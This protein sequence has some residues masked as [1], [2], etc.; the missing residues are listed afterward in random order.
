MAITRI[1]LR[2]GTASQWSNANPVLAVREVGVETD[3]RS[4]KIGDGATPWSLLPYALSTVVIAALGADLDSLETSVS[5]L[6]ATVSTKA[7]A[8]V[9]TSHAANGAGHPLAT[10][11]AP[12]MQSAADKAKLDALE[13][14]SLSA[15]PNTPAAPKGRDVSGVTVHH[16]FQSGHGWTLLGGT[17]ADLNATNAG[18]VQG[19]QCAWFQGNGN[20]SVVGMRRTAFP[21]V[22]LTGRNLGLLLRVDDPNNIP[23]TGGTFLIYLGNSSFANF[24]TVSLANDAAYRF[25]PRRST[26]A[27][28]NGGHWQHVTIPLDAGSPAASYMSVSGAQTIAQVLANVTDWQIY[29]RD[30]AASTPSRIAVQE[31]Y[32]FPQPTRY[33]N[34]VCCITF[35]DG[36][37]STLTKAAPILAAAGAQGTLYVINDSIG[38]DGYLSI[39]ELTELGKRYRWEIGH[40]AYG[41]AVH[42]YPG[43]SGLSP[44]AGIEDVQLGRKW[45][46]DNGYYAHNHIA[47]PHGA[48]GIDSSGVGS[49][50][51]QADVNF[52]PYFKTGR[53]VYNQMPETVPPAD[54]M[55]LRTY[56]ATNSTTTIAAL[57][58]NLDTAKRTKSAAICVFH[59]LIDSGTRTAS[60]WYT[61][62]FQELVTYAG[63]IGMPIRT[64][65]EVFGGW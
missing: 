5:A 6:S 41:G 26:Y 61:A 28:P 27:T 62:D 53:L 23:Q 43:Y 49:A 55:K 14:I 22:D 7:D 63:S 35:D 38:D 20:N 17:T 3:T 36:L 12:G 19:T 60:Q 57:K 1:Q 13:A 16:S 4:F 50:N 18:H 46:R 2:G 24:V 58:A 48:V 29:H 51:D 37:R 64:V 56:W 33:P 15:V 39:A 44:A 32:S 40:H 45:L 65:P 9:L 52:A 11:V 10:T 25:F 30:P 59:D 42:N 31:I 8:S 21:S 54:T 47:Y 34:G